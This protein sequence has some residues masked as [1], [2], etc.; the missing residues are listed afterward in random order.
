M[1][2]VVKSSEVV[3]MLCTYIVFYSLMLEVTLSEIVLK[4]FMLGGNSVRDPLDPIPNS[5]VK[6][7][8]ADDSVVLI[9]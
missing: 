9:M 8:C 4:S 2:L 5:I 6:A 3:T 7:F 1:K